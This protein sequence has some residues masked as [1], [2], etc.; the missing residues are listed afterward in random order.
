MSNMPHDQ[1]Q[2]ES[3]DLKKLFFKYLPYWYLFAIAIVL[4][5]VLAFVNNRLTEEVYS[6]KSTV[7]IREDRMTMPLLM[8]TGMQQ[9]RSHWFNEK[10]ILRSYTMIE[11]TLAR[12]D[13][14]VSYYNIDRTL[15][16]LIRKE[17]YHH[18]PFRVE[19]DNAHPQP[20]D[21]TFTVRILDAN[22]Y[23]ISVE[24]D[25]EGFERQ[26]TIRFGEEVQGPEYAFSLDWVAEYDAE[27]HE[28][29]GY[30]FIIHSPQQLTN[31]YKRA[32]NVSPMGQNFSIVEVNFE[33]TN[34]ERGL[35]F[36]NMLAD[37]YLEQNLAEKNQTSQNTIEFIDEQLEEVTMSLDE[38]ETRLQEFREDEQLLDIS[39]L[40]TQILT[41]L[42][43]LDQ[44]RQM[45]QLKQQYYDFLLEYVRD[46]REFT[47][48][49][50]PASLGIEDP[51]L[52][53]ILLE[54]SKLHN[55]KARLLLTTTE[56]SPSVQAI[57]KEIEQSKATLEENLRSIRAASDIMMRDLNERIA[58]KESRVNQLPQTER[59]L[60]GIE[61][62]FNINDATYNFL[63]EKRAEAGI[64]LASNMPDHKVV[65]P[66]R[67]ESIVS[68][69]RQMNYALALALGIF[70][71]GMFLVMRDFFNTRILDKDEVTKKL[72]FPI[73]G[74]VPHQ[75]GK[76]GIKIPGIVVYDQPRSNILEAFRSMRSNL[77]FFAPDAQNKMIV[78]SSTRANEGKTFTALNLA[79]ALALSNRKTLFIDA[80]L[81]KPPVVIDRA[82]R[83]RGLSNHLIGQLKL[84]DILHKSRQ[85]DN[86]YMI[87]GGTIPPNPPELLDHYTMDTLL[88]N[89]RE[90]FEFI[91]VDT[92]P[93]GLV[94][95][96]QPLLK[97]ADMVMYIIR[98]NFSRQ[99]DLDFIRDFSEKTRLKNMVITINDV[100]TGTTH[101]GYGYGYGAGYGYGLGYGAGY[102]M[103]PR[104]KS[105]R[106]GRFFARGK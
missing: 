86:L 23:E 18:T 8:E 70:L 104:K 48:V 58:T 38:A 52:N 84:E 94:A 20:F 60:I 64:S 19:W 99:T 13:V 25:V 2:E 62:I 47:E 59:E 93:L 65:D 76:K 34:L 85:N 72:G 91:I 42:Q 31:R 28:G 43:E 92:P 89:L 78:V 75:G 11:Q 44:Q 22:T 56:R 30:E 61:R 57:N 68:P 74:L 10:A 17:I 1:F 90:E 95:D 49:F 54:L 26:K 16:S 40:A 53:N 103:E 15:G 55:E 71:P 27:E 5:G 80:D 63:L 105:S 81:R 102:G 50:A 51:I 82:Y 97:R 7:L 46:E 87:S 67:F 35:D 88:A 41:E 33:A 100:K 45:E 21:K 98:H 106:L 96:A 12:M 24:N 29:Q 101:S 32:L 4:A 9:G 66:A 79:G 37:T 14:G 39:I 36:V 3:I 83:E 77:Q 6:V 73:V 69:R